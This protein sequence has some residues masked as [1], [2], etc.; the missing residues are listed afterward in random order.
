MIYTG[1]RKHLH[2]RVFYSLLN[3]LLQ[4]PVI[5][6]SIL[7]IHTYIPNFIKDY[8]NLEWDAVIMVLWPNPIRN[9]LENWPQYIGLST[10]R[11]FPTKGESS[12]FWKLPAGRTIMQQQTAA[13]ANVTVQCWPLAIQRSTTVLAATKSVPFIKK[14]FWP[15]D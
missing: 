9:S 10:V 1:T 12:S 14:L 11:W 4:L 8:Y 15:S 13:T 5:N 2:G 7:P 3:S 6:L